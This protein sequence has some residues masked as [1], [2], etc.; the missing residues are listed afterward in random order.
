MAPILSGDPATGGG[1]VIDMISDAI[2][3]IELLKKHYEEWKVL[4]ALFDW[5]GNRIEGDTQLEVERIPEQR[6]P[7]V[8]FYR[9]KGPEDYVFV[10]MPVVA[11]LYPDYALAGGGP[12]TDAN[13][14]RYVNTPLSSFSKGAS[15]TRV[16]FIVYGYRPKDLL[17]AKK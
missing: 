16:N 11:G 5:Q 17:K 2:A 8:W 13:Y 6:R 10:H 15:N 7:D 4:S 14:F 9:V 3:L 12:N 1:S